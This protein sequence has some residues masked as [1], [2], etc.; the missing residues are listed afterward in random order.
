MPQ[1]MPMMAGAALELLRVRDRQ[2]IF[3]AAWFFL[4]ADKGSFESALKGSCITR[5]GL[6]GKGEPIPALIAEFAESLPNKPV[7]RKRRSTPGT[8]S[9][10][11]RHE[12]LRMMTRLER[13]LEMTLR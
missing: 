10:R 11:P 9:P 3:E 4:A 7:S 6:C 1:A 5:Q 2:V 8:T 13:R 12:V